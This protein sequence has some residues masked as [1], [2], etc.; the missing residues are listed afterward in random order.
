MP[1][2]TRAATKIH[3]SPPPRLIDSASRNV[4]APSAARI[5]ATAGAAR[6]TS[7]G[8]STR[9]TTLSTRASTALAGI[10]LAR[11]CSD[12]EQDCG[13]DR[14]PLDA[15]EYDEPSAHGSAD[16][17]G[18]RAG[19][20]QVAAGCHQLR[21]LRCQLGNHRRLRR[22]RRPSATAGCR[23]PR[24]RTQATATNWRAAMR[25]PHARGASR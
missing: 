25:T 22:S 10:R 3:S 11:I 1:A 7:T 12:H 4:R 18:D 19:A 9:M 24:D 17:A 21:S 8:V 23:T 13:G 14:Q 5:V 15:E 16:S 6:R 2:A 20:R